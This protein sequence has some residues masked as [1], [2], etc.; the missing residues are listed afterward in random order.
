MLFCTISYNIYRLKNVLY[1]SA[2]HISK[3]SIQEPCT[4]MRLS[5][6]FGAIFGV[7][8]GASF[9]SNALFCLLLYRKPIWLKKP[10]NILLLT[11]AAI[12]MMTGN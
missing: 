7:I 9:A 5:Q 12:D 2:V 4:S 1:L 6:D 11:L 10:H 8:G 3:R